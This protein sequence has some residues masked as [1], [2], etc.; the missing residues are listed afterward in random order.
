MNGKH[1]SWEKFVMFVMEFM[2][3]LLYRFLR[4]IICRRENEKSQTE[5]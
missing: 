2:T 1:T 3:P 5:T 4:I